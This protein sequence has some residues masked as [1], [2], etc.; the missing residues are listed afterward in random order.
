MVL[1]FF[2]LFFFSSDDIADSAEAAVPL[3]GVI[4]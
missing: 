1:L 3:V 4:R 2:L